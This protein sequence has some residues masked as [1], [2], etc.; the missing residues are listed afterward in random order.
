MAAIV[1]NDDDPEGDFIEV[2][3]SIYTGHGYL[4]ATEYWSFEYLDNIYQQA[5]AIR[6]H[7]QGETP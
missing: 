5:L 1:M 7:Q 3:V 2:T 4:E 6:H